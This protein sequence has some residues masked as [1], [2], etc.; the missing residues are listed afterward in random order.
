MTF[1]GWHDSDNTFNSTKSDSWV[2]QDNLNPA[3]RIGS[4]R[5]STDTY[6][7]RKQYYN[8]TIDGFEYF[9]RAQNDPV[10]ERNLSILPKSVYTFASGAEYENTEDSRRTYN[11]TYRVPCRGTYIKFEPR[12]SGTLIVYLVQNGS[13]DYHYGVADDAANASKKY[14]QIKWRPLFITDETGR[15]VTM[16]NSFGN[17]SK[18][19]PTGEDNNNAGS[20]T[21]GISRCNKYE[22]AIKNAWGYGGAQASA[23]ESGCSFDWSNFKGTDEDRKNLLR[24]WPDKGERESIIRLASGGFVLPHKAY[25]R[26]SF[27][28]KAGKTYY[29]FQSGSK[30]ELGGFSFVPT[31]FPDECKYAITSKPGALVCNST[32]QERNYAGGMAKENDLHGTRFVKIPEGSKNSI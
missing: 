31:G 30:P 17:V 2:Y 8:R 5:P 25:V 27:H 29:V 4:E 7:Q 26:Y 15:P 24:A 1:G 21:L 11:T 16:V 18:Y 22:D 9:T 10:D 13:V 14:Y 20:F 19:L 32:N 6:E 23:L 28:V 12:E 3:D